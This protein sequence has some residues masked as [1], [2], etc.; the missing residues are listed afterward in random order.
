MLMHGFNALLARRQR[1]AY[2]HRNDRCRV[3][4]FPHQTDRL[5]VRKARRKGPNVFVTT[6]QR[7]SKTSFAGLCPTAYIP[8]LNIEKSLPK[9][10]IWNK[11]ANQRRTTV[12]INFN[13]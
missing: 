5:L 13:L 6:H 4:G 2:R 11:N 1:R 7:R 10:A 12:V 3:V 9:G 8:E